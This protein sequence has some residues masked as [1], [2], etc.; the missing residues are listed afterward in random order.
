MKFQAH[1][2]PTLFLA[3]IF[4][5]GHTFGQA[6]KRI[7]PDLNLLQTIEQNFGDAM[8]QYKLLGKQLPRDS[9]PKTYHSTTRRYEFSDAAWWCSGFYPGTLLYLYETTKD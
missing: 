8:D 5:A 3:L 7:R 4:L 6:N 9:F 1:Y 2:T